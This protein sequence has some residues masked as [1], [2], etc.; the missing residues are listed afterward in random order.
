MERPVAWS[1]FHCTSIAIIFAVSLLFLLIGLVC[2]RK[3]V[4]WVLFIVSSL[5][6]SLE[7]VKQLYVSYTP[8]TDVW[9]YNWSH[10]P[11]QFCSTPMY[12][13]LF[14]SFCR[15]GK[16]YDAATAFIATYGLFAGLIVL[17]TP[18][19]V[20]NTHLFLNVHTMIY[21]GFMLV[22]PAFL[23]GS[24]TVKPQF[25]VMQKAIP[26]LLVL[27]LM[28]M[29]MN[30][31][32]H[33]YGNPDFKFNMFYISPYGET[34]LDFLNPI[35]ENMSAISIAIGYVV[36]FTTAAFGTLLFA[37]LIK[38][39]SGKRLYDKKQPDTQDERNEEQE[40]KQELLP[41]NK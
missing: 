14:A 21:H 24:G 11:F 27:M 29:G 33:K 7:V 34:P 22:I 12:V 26:V 40:R 1:K 23:Y 18:S 9:K 16:V 36:L 19:T 3:H 32:Y 2:K 20:Y 17:A 25:N 13:M 41:Q 30:E 5:L 6:I 4:N 37:M 10:F 15:K 8:S 38:L 28:A 31:A 39:C 35:I